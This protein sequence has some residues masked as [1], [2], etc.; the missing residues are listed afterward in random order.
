MDRC[1]QEAELEV[2]E[3]LSASQPDRVGFSVAVGML[4][5]IL[6]PGPMAG[7]VGTLIGFACGGS[8]AGN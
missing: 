5:G 7:E 3:L 8:T 6:A 4:L 2:R 1:R